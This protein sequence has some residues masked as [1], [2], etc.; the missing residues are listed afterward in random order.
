MAF[1]LNIDTATESASVCLAKDDS[2]VLMRKS[3]Q[4]KDHAS[5]L[6][7]AIKQMME[8]ADTAL[9]KID[10]VAVTIG[11]G[12]Y[13]GLR[14][15]LAAVK[16]ICYALEK[17][18]IAVNTLLVM[19]NAI[20]KEKVD[21]LCPM[22]DARR[23]EVFTA[24]YTKDL[25]AVKE[26]QALIIEQSSFADMLLS[27]TICFSGSGSEKCKKII[28]SSNAR[29][30]TTV[31]NAAAMAELTYFLYSKKQFADLAYIEPTYLKEFHTP[32]R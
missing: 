10:A 24:V 28:N 9:I 26:P 4:Q 13:T 3:E 8:E 6:H 15:G 20:K 22:I 21:L 11:P 1:I 17:P 18:L 14:I 27:K 32:V 7:V 25:E 29:F 31:S 16:G 19:A 23:N 12:S 2:V 5:W 30:S